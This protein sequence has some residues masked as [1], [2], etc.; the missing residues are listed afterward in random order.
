MSESVDYLP[1]PG[2]IDAPQT[3]A[4]NVQ[5]IVPFHGK[6]SLSLVDFFN[7][8]ATGTT[9]VSTL[10]CWISDDYKDPGNGDAAGI[11]AAEA[12]AHWSITTD[13]ALVAWLAG[14]G[15]PAGVVGNSNIQIT[16]IICAAFRFRSTYA[17]G[18]GHF[19]LDAEAQ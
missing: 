9:L 14:A 13:A 5:T 4:G 8:D 12:R 17:S 11:A 6:K 2:L 18:A 7:D 19:R 10:Q 1:L 15:K 16:Q 3:G